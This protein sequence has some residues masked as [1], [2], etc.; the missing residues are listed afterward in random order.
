MEEKE[1]EK[2]EPHLF[3]TVKVITDETFSRHEGFDLAVFDKK[4]QTPSQLP[5]FRVLKQMTYPAFKSRVAQWLSYPESRVRLWGLAT[6]QNK[7]MRLDKPISEKEPLLSIPLG[8]CTGY[9]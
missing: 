2:E 5:T 3:L 7:T 9:F 8:C 6:R 1:K 4:N